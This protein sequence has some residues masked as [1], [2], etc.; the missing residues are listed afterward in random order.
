MRTYSMDLRD[1]VV[2][3]CDE[4]LDTREEI[5]EQFGVSKSWIRRLLQRRRESGTYAARKGHRG[6]KPTFDAK[7]L[8]ELDDLAERFPDAT[9]EELRART[10]APCSLVTIFNTLVR[11]GYRRK[12]RR[13]GLLSKIAMTSA[14]NDGSGNGGVVLLTRRGSFSSTKAGPR[15]T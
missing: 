6:R 14:G 2:A 10:G 4:G 1:R 13:S 12:K 11:L 9:L 7:L 3:A 15:R 8:K 5:A